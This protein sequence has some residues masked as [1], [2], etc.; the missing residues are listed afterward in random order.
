MAQNNMATSDLGV[1]GQV[2]RGVCRH[3]AD[4]G[5]QSLTEFRLRNGRRADILAINRDGHVVLVEVKSSEAD[6]R[7]DSK[8]PDYLPF[9]ER[10]YF[11]VPPRFPTELLPT[12]HGLIV[13]DAYDAEIVRPADDRPL[14]GTRRRHLI[15]RFALTAA[16]RLQGL[17][18]PRI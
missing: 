7:T 6:F 2:A 4:L 13:A 16:A 5:Y 10:F 3:F 15:L 11:A 18:D 12:D 1:A 17:A 8:W 14:N 9:C